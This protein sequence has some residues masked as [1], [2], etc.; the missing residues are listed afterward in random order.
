GFTS[1]PPILAAK[2]A[3]AATF[4]HESNAIP[5][6]ANRWLSR[7][8]NRA[9]V[10]FPSACRRLKNRSVTVT[11]TPVRPPFHPRDVRACRTD[12]GL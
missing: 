6:R 1:A 9:F 4:L 10:G 7:V 5:G 8:V 3:G 2:A 12:L 11:G